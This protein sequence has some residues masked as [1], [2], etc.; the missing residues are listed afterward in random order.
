MNVSQ[1]HCCRAETMLT[2]SSWSMQSTEGWSPANSPSVIAG[3]S[4]RPMC[5]PSPLAGR[6]FSVSR[7][8]R[9]ARQDTPCSVRPRTT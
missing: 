6:S 9:N 7:S 8:S 2:A 5:R 1:A 4:G 3:E